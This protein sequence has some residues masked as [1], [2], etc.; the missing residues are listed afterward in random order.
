M[1]H[2][3]EIGSSNR[4]PSERMIS[5]VLYQSEDTDISPVVVSMRFGLRWLD[6]RNLEVSHPKDIAVAS[7][8][9]ELEGVRVQFAGGHGSEL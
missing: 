3:L 6:N 1:L 9:F 5:A 7:G 8:P 4:D 2:T